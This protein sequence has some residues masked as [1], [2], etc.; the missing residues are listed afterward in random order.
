MPFSVQDESTQH[1]LEK[2]HHLAIIKD[3]LGGAALAHLEREQVNSMDAGVRDL[4]NKSINDDVWQYI[5][6]KRT[7]YNM[8]LETKKLFDFTCIT[9]INYELNCKWTKLHF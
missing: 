1:Q 3:C 9:N 7:A 8:Y 6:T 2:A 5:K 4:I